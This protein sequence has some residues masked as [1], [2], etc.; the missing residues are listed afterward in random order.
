[1][2]NE[3]GQVMTFRFEV[4]LDEVYESLEDCCTG[5]EFDERLVRQVLLSDNQ[6]LVLT[7]L[8]WG[9]GDTEV[10]EELL[11]GMAKALVGRPWPLNMEDIDLDEFIAR[12]EKAHAE[13]VAQKDRG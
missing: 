7:A 12:V 8:R 1:M 10:R 6:A 5:I 3:S 4:P 2:S 11:S 9:W 13:W